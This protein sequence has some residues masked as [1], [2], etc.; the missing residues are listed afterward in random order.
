MAFR[1]VKIAFKDIG[2]KFFQ[3]GIIASLVL[4]AQ[5]W[6]IFKWF[7]QGTLPL[8]WNWV[9]IGIFLGVIALIYIS[10]GFFTRFQNSVA[11]RQLNQQGQSEEANIFMKINSFMGSNL[12]IEDE[13]WII[14]SK[15]T[16]GFQ[17]KLIKG[18]ERP[19]AKTTS[20]I[21][22]LLS[23]A[24]VSGAIYLASVYMTAVPQSL[25][26]VFGI[27]M[28]ISITL[29]FTNEI[30]YAKRGT[31]YE[32]GTILKVVSGL[33]SATLFASTLAFTTYALGTYVFPG[34][35]GSLGTIFGL[36][37]AASIVVG[38]AKKLIESFIINP[39]SNSCKGGN[40]D[41][42]MSK[43]L[44]TSGYKGNSADAFWVDI[45]VYNNSNN[46]TDLEESMQACYL[47]EV[48]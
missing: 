9:H 43:Q 24:A 47:I 29:N 42:V 31:T 7:P 4:L 20:T 17:Y 35:A 45:D 16:S 5:T 19:L 32:Q 18:E 23:V 27:S 33:V 26:I 36:L 41:N 6:I 22:Y 30:L 10:I 28:L 1:D 12:A 8:Q 13:D 48:S 37:I 34:A 3:L 11:R 14:K 2:R 38:M 39:I 25:L 21:F 46:T 44:I 40:N 15:N